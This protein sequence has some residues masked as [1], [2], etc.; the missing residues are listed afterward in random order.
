MDTWHGQG[1]TC[2]KLKLMLSDMSDSSDIG[3]VRYQKRQEC[4]Y[5]AKSDI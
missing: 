2:L 1:H 3:I 4:R 5:R